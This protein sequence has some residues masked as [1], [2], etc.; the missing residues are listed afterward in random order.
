M[1]GAWYIYIYVP[2][3]WVDRSLVLRISD[4]PVCIISNGFYM[5]QPFTF[6]P[7][8]IL[9][10]SCGRYDLWT[11]L[12]YPLMFGHQSPLF[13]NPV[14]SL[15]SMS[16][17]KCHRNIYENTRWKHTHTHVRMQM[18][19]F[20]QSCYQKAGSRAKHYGAAVCISPNS[21]PLSFF[22]LQ[23]LYLNA[24]LIYFKIPTFSKH[25]TIYWAVHVIMVWHIPMVPPQ[26]ITAELYPINAQLHCNN[27]KWQIHVSASK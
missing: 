19:T 14:Y 7:S 10:I 9:T 3:S 16:R 25:K 8:L 27:Y 17:I 4:K 1:S 22:I 20:Q 18:F 11:F 5:N 24:N 23:S 15:N 12:Q 6:P 13:L 21:F 2:K 26:C